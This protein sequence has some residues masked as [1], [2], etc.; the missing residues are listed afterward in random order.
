MKK[1][2]GV[3]CP[4]LLV[5]VASCAISVTSALAAPEWLIAEGPVTTL[6][7][8]KDQG[9]L[10]LA[11]S[12]ASFLGAS[13]VDC[14][15]TLEGTVGPAGE[16]EFTQIQ[17]L[18]GKV[19]KGNGLT[20]GF[21]ECKGEQGCEGNGLVYPIGLPWLSKLELEGTSLIDDTIASSGSLGFAVECS[22]FGI[23]EEDECTTSLVAPTIENMAT[24]NDVLNKFSISGSFSFELCSLSGEKSGEITGESLKS[25]LS[26]S[27]LA[28]SG[29]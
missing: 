20:G 25:S 10:L 28:V 16:N 6:T 26:G 18:E 22:I 4:A 1:M 13:E 5:L 24:E 9:L 17:G 11:D 15:G 14:E 19:T 7:S 2:I 21:I 8:I 3:A 23:K 27:K 29:E 12:K